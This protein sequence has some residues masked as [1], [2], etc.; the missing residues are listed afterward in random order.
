MTLRRKLAT[1]VRRAMAPR[2]RFSVS[3]WAATHRRLSTESSA[4]PG[5]WSNDRNP[6][7]TEIMD[8]MG[9]RDIPIVVV[10]AA[11]QTG[12]TEAL[13]NTQGMFITQQPGPI[14]MVLPTRDMARP[15]S[16][17]RFAPMVRDTPVLRAVCYA[18][19]TRDSNTTITERRFAGGVI[20]YVGANSPVPLSSRPIRDVMCDEVDRFPLTVGGEGNP[21]DLAW[22]RTQAFPDRTLTLTSTPTIR[23]RS[24][25]HAWYGRGDQRRLLA[26]RTR[27]FVPLFC[28]RAQCR[29]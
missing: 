20:T 24:Q 15:V 8:A 12:K 21:I 19:S 11:A 4:E 22:K 18:P 7:M 3:E 17:D 13:L 29:Y 1:L 28:R 25:V 6:V 16:I 5:R 27:K 9:D 26:R 14:L 23:G 2:P 10:M